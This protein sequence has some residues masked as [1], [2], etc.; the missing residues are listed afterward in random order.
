MAK[1]G[2]NFRDIYLTP[3]SP[4]RK[5]Y[6]KQRNITDLGDIAATNTYYQDLLATQA[7]SEFDKKACQERQVVNQ[8]KINELLPSKTLLET[9]VTTLQNSITTQ[10]TNLDAS[11]VIMTGLEAGG[12][13]SMVGS[14]ATLTPSAASLLPITVG[15]TTFTTTTQVQAHIN[16][17]NT[18]VSTLIQSQNDLTGHYD[19]YTKLKN[20]DP[21]YTGLL[22][23]Q[24]ANYTGANKANFASLTGFS[25]EAQNLTQLDSYNNTTNKPPVYGYQGELNDINQKIASLQEDCNATS[26]ANDRRLAELEELTIVSLIK[27]QEKVLGY[28]TKFNPLTIAFKYRTLKAINPKTNILEFVDKEF[29]DN[30]ALAKVENKINNLGR[31]VSAFTKAVEGRPD[32]VSQIKDQLNQYGMFD[33][34]LCGLLAMDFDGSILTTTKYHIPFQ[35]IDIAGIKVSKKA[36]YSDE[37]PVG[38][39]EPVTVYGSSSAMQITI[40][41]QYMAYESG[42]NSDEGFIQELKDRFLAATFP[43]YG[44][45]QRSGVRTYG[46]PHK[47]VLNMFEKFVNIPVIIE[48]VSFE[49]QGGTDNYTWLAMGF[50]INLT[51]KTSYRVAQ[52]ISGDEVVDRGVR[53]LAHKNNF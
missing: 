39:Y 44:N 12:I 42:Y 6:E 27:D 17:T 16:T 3:M 14:S 9:Q 20:S 30:S 50:K 28:K 49:D 37:T 53:A 40:P 36:N 19:N 4:K 24:K 18:Q 1:K 35:H 25:T 41:L 38:R 33:P 45:Y 5:S 2:F 31:K 48:D 10:Q 8:Q 47:Y 21:P 43:V 15:M 11:N 34:A 23:Y 7:K 13:I 26:E 22:G 46:A 51:L 52:V 32:A 29:R